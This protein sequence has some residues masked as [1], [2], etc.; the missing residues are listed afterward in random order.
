MSI[1]ISVF[2]VSYNQK[3][4]IEQAIQSVV[5]QKLSPFEIIISDDCSTDG[6]WE[7][8]QGYAKEFPQLIKASR[9]DPN[10]GI[11]QNFNKA[12]HMTTGNLITCVAGDDFIK[13]GYFEA[14]EECI[15]KENLNP[16]KDNFI[17]IPNVINLFENGLETKYN[18]V[19]HKNKNLL[20]LRLRGLID[21][22]YGLVSRSSLTQTADFL[23]SIGVH[24]DFVWGI[25]RYIHSE[26]IYFLDGYFSVYRQGVGIVSRTKEIDISKSLLSAIEVIKDR[27]GKDF[28][29]KDKLFIE[30]LKAKSEYQIDRSFINYLRL[31]RQTYY[32]FNNFGS[33]KKLFKAITYLF[34]PKKLKTILFKFKHI[35]SLSK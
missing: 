34:L 26:N 11:F 8:I 2:I 25:D 21:D 28:D 14:V 22:R 12:T 5:N 3:E 30:Y 33:S 9:N 35:E 7:I 20:K 4:Y 13:D 1:K 18:N 6:T 23:E 16:D 10:I 24:A 27:F 19:I 31:F 15:K 17:I 29:S 32:N